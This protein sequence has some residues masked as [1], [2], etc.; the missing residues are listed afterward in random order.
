MMA[1]GSAALLWGPALLLAA[2]ALNL[3]LLVAA[4]PALRRALSG[5]RAL[6]RLVPRSSG[7]EVLAF[8]PR[9]ATA[10]PPA[11]RRLPVSVAAAAPRRLAA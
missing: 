1:S 4:A 10:P 6:V 11:Q 5:P 8:A 7:A 2:L 3:W 9:P